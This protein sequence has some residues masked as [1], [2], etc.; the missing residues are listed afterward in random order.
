M[1]DKLLASKYECKLKYILKFG[2]PCGSN[3]CDH[4]GKQ[5]FSSLNHVRLVTILNH[6]PTFLD[7]DNL[8]FEMC[9]K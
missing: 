9:H 1:E 5:R 4:I 3:F 6:V 2:V 8:Y 7:S